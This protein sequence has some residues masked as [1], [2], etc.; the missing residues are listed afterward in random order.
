MCNDLAAVPSYTGCSRAQ[1]EE[2]IEFPVS[3]ELSWHRTPRTEICRDEIEILE[4]R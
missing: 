3:Q 2:G 1:Q 4:R